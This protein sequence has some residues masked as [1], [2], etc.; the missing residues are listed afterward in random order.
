MPSSLRTPPNDGTD[1]ICLH[2]LV[3]DTRA[4]NKDVIC[5]LL[6]SFSNKH[7]LNRI[8]EHEID[9]NTLLDTAIVTGNYVVVRALL[10]RAGSL[11]F[12]PLKQHTKSS[13]HKAILAGNYDIFTVLLLFLRKYYKLIENWRD[14]HESFEEIIEWI[15]DNGNSPLLQACLLPN[16]T[17]YVSSLLYNGANC[18]MYNRLNRRTCF[19]HAAIAGEISYFKHL[20]RQ[21]VHTISY[22]SALPR[23]SR[24]KC[25]PLETDMN[26]D[27]VM[28]LAVKHYQLET[29][30]YL[31]KLGMY[32]PL[33]NNF[34]KENNSL[35]HLAVMNHSRASSDRV[36]AMTQLALQVERKSFLL[37]QKK[38][39]YKSVIDTMVSYRKVIFALNNQGETPLTIA[40]VASTDLYDLVLRA[41]RDIYGD[42][43]CADSIGIA[44]DNEINLTENDQGN[45]DDYAFAL[46]PAKSHAQY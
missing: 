2:K 16:R 33:L 22:P 1:Y 15:D 43:N 35:V 38:N 5:D 17:Q 45:S 36:I 39:S 37:Y 44:V 21:Q 42:T 23:L 41:S 18:A 30:Q 20:L 29:A 46:S 31:Y 27:T 4:C 25:L 19:M 14:K 40:R 11:C 12:V 34:N 28:H 26:G 9:G 10:K 6:S 3:Q 13:L 32:H 24:Y 7:I 8:L